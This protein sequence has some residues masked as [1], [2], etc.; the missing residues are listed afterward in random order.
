MIFKFKKHNTLLYN[1]LLKL[2]RNLY[3]YKEIGL[4]DTF[5]TRIYLMFLHFSLMLIIFKFKNTKFPQNEYDSLFQCIENNLRELGQ[6]DVAVNKKMKDLNKIFYDILLKINNKKDKFDI[7][8]DLILKYFADQN[9]IN[10]KKYDLFIDYLVDF[11]NFC[12]ELS[13]QSMIKDAIKF[14]DI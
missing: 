7:N 8:K 9:D 5:E 11:Y 13:P 12:F 3:F 2:S 6:G 14:K 10:N 1:T 4:K